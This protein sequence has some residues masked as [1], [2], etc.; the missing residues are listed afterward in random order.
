[1]R[2]RGNGLCM[3]AFNQAI[4]GLRDAG[5]AVAL[6][7]LSIWLPIQ[8]AVLVLA[9]LL[10][11]LLGALTRRRMDVGTLTMGWPVYLRLITRA[12]VAHLGLLVFIL[13]LIVVHAAL[14]SFGP[15]YQ[16][17]L[18]SAGINLATAWVVIALVASIISNHFLYR[19][20]AI[21]AWTLAALSILGL[22]GPTADLL[23]SIAITI[24][25]LRLSPLLALKIV[26][27]LLITV[28]LAIAV[29]NFFDRRL[30]AVADLTPSLQVLLAKLIR[31]TLLTI[32][33]VLVLGTVGVDLSAL[34]LFS[35]AVGV[36]IGLGLQKIV[37]NFVGGII[38]LADKSI[39]P[40]DVV[41]VGDGFGWVVS[42]NARHTVV[43]RRDGREILIPNEDLITERVVNWSY[44][45]NEI[46]I[47]LPFPVDVASDPQQVRR[48]ALAAVAGVDRV[49]AQ[50]A[51]VCHFVGFSAASLDFLLRFWIEDPE[52]GV[53]NIKSTVLLALWDGMKREGVMIPSPIQDLRLRGTT[54]LAA[55]LP[56]GLPPDTTQPRREQIP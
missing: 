41:S 46:R 14:R 7:F 42:M 36:G 3:D 9:G 35:G 55:T 4:D 44:S 51:P 26:V 20:V 47:D 40:G 12:V 25:G 32:A 27:L 31:L 38:L 30:H 24:G 37:S 18:V 43:T 39:K 21:S 52:S 16:G 11:G 22:L 13:L 33:I 17:Y 28:W 34:A 15:G 8:I 23:N 19:L 50:P 29:S 49:L 54:K 6:Q 48:I 10:A 53:T 45:K 2:L 5:Q 1:M 56:D